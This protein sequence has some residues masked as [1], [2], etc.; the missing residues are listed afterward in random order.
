MAA[1]TA[2]DIMQHGI[3][4]ACVE[5]LDDVMMKAVNKKEGMSWPEK[6]TLFFK[7]T[8]SSESGMKGDIERTRQISQENQGSKFTFAKTT[9][10]A[11]K[12]W[13]ARKVKPFSIAPRDKVTQVWPGRFILCS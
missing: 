9:E 10:E 2:R 4:I 7:F 12:L 8:G 11:E 1:K 5:M 13:Y 6:P 3:G